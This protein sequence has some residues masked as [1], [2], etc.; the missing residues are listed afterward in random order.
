V[1]GIL[2]FSPTRQ[3]A[4]LP[5]S[6]WRGRLCFVSKPKM[7]PESNLLSALLKTLDS[8]DTS[9]QILANAKSGNLT[10]AF[11]TKK[12]LAARMGVPPI[13]VDKL[14]HQG[15]ASKGKSGLVEGRHYCKLH[16]SDNNTNSF[17]YDSAKVLKDAWTSFTGYEN[18]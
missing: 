10:T 7:K 15:V 6:R 13:A 8:I 11:I 5:R 12:A 3:G 1:R 14:V 2:A 4:S 17:L 9:L 16:P 18:E